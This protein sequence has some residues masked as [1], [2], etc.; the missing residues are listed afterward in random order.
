MLF[1]LKMYRGTKM[2][3]QQDCHGRGIMAEEDYGWLFVDPRMDMLWK[4]ID[5]CRLA[6]LDIVFTDLTQR[7][8]QGIISTAQFE[9]MARM[10]YRR[11]SESID[12]VL[13]NLHGGQLPNS[14]DFIMI[15]DKLL[16]DIS[17]FR[18]QTVLIDC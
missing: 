1:R 7:F 12:D 17:S 9:R 13:Y 14:A 4:L 8:C 18:N 10:V 15:R 5:S 16:A 2:A 6:L 3:N 11:I